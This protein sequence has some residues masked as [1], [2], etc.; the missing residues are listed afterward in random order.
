M[1]DEGWGSGWGSATDG[2]GFIIAM[3]ALA[4]SFAALFTDR[5]YNYDK[6]RMDYKGYFL[7]LVTFRILG[8][9]IIL[10]I[11]Y[12]LLYLIDLGVRNNFF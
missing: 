2:W 1:V 10:G 11:G 8:A 4:L 12:G 6:H 9:L 5:P 7:E 3:L